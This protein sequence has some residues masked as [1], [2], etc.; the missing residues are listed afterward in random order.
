MST[1]DTGLAFS[2]PAPVS[3]PPHKDALRSY[4]P[5][6]GVALRPHTDVEGMALGKLPYP[7]RS[8]CQIGFQETGL[9]DGTGCPA[10]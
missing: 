6:E 8:M 5:M 1:S 2:H 3:L 7:G 10:L 4:F 9:V